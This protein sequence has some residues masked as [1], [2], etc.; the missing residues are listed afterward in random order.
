MLQIIK[1][2]SIRKKIAG[3]VIPSTIAFGLL[4]TILALFYLRDFKTTIFKDLEVVM[5]EIV[6]TATPETTA[7]L[8]E[9]LEQIQQNADKKLKGTAIL[10]SS[11][12][13]GVIILATAGALI[14]SGAIGPPV[15]NI[16]KGHPMTRPARSVSFSMS[17]WKSCRASCP[18]CSRAASNSTRPRPQPTS[19]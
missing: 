6:Q 2:F 11:I 5:T 17:L 16:A 7:R 1:D 15:Q 9:Q 10:L 4:M 3:F 18:I 13:V 19:T 8:N 12:V 14:I